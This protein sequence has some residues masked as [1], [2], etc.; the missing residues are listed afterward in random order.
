MLLPLDP[1]VALGGGTASGLEI[2]PVGHR[3]G[4]VGGLLQL[5]G[6]AHGAVDLGGA[7]AGGLLL[8]RLLEHG[9]GAALPCHGLS[10]GQIGPLPG[11]LEMGGLAVP[12]GLGQMGDAPGEASRR[13]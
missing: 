12:G 9:V 11:L 8:F 10:G 6:S 5:L 13:A 1:P 2:S 3:A 4:P 7:G